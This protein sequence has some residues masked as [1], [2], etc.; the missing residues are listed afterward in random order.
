MR[1]A[2]LSAAM[3]KSPLVA[4]LRDQFVREPWAPQRGLKIGHCNDVRATGL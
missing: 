3:E 2:M 4:R 1:A